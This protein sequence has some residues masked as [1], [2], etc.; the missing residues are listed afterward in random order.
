MLEY[1]K[2]GQVVTHPCAPFKKS[3]SSSCLHV[4]SLAMYHCKKGSQGEYLYPP[5]LC[6]WTPQANGLPT[7]KEE[8]CP[9]PPPPNNGPHL[10][11]EE[12]CY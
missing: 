3:S 9:P 6:Q 4:L 11:K 12:S 1:M 10:G 5:P 8:S 2:G 7:H